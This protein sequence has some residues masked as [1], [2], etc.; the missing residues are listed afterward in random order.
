MSFRKLLLNR[1]QKEFEKEKEDEKGLL[2]KNPQ[3]KGLSVGNNS[4]ETCPV[5]V[6]YFQQL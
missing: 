2:E 6:I 1:C 4:C 3:L 5:S